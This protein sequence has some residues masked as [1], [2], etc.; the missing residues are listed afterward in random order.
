MGT[1]RDSE[2]S[3]VAK[4]KR[5]QGDGSAGTLPSYTRSAVAAALQVSVTT[6]RRWEGTLLHPE[7]GSDGIHRFDRLE[8]EALSRDRPP[9]VVQRD[10]PSSGEIA[11]AVFA[12]FKQGMDAKDVVIELELEPE[13]VKKL[14]AE[15]ELM[16]GR[17]IVGEQTLKRLEQMAAACLLDQDVLMALYNDDFESLSEYIQEKLAERRR[18]KRG[19]D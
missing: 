13:L 19:G 10:E 8:V 9:P 16:S 18:R 7:K 1:T 15:W 6:I 4:A 12:L 17:L 5:C 3:L 2:E 14:Q 11:A